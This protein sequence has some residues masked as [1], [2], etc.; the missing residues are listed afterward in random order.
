MN[1]IL[2]QRGRD[3]QTYWR[4]VDCSCLGRATTDENDQVIAENQRHDHTPESAPAAVAK[5][6]D[7]MKQRAINE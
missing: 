2:N 6:A 1:P 3:G 4:C 7:K 5:V